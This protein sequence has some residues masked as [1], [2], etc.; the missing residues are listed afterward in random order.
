M[1]WVMLCLTL[2]FLTSCDRVQ[3]RSNR[4][5]IRLEE[6]IVTLLE[7]N[8]YEHVYRDLVYFG[9]ERSFLF[10][11]TMER[12]TLFSVD[13][14]VRAG[15]DLSDG[16]T[17]RPDRSSPGRIAVAIPRSKILMVDADESTLREYM[18]RERGGRI[19]LLEMSGQLEAV[20]ARTAADA[21]RRG[22]L[23]RAD[24]NARALVTSLLSM[25]GFDDVIYD[26]ST[27][28]GER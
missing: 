12:A 1:R 6:K 16:V 28:G 10:I 13:I 24:A 9:E 26:Q 19:G 4:S 27:P 18:I 15:V 20:K 22:I 5:T 17:L 8:T 25:A 21:V 3:D 2:L 11:R 7:L 23:T 14:R